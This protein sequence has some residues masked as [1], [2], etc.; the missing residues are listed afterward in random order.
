[1][2]RSA[3]SARWNS[4][5]WFVLVRISRSRFTDTI[6]KNARLASEIFFE[7]PVIKVFQH[8]AS[9]THR[10]MMKNHTLKAAWEAWK[11]FGHKLGDFQARLILTVFYFAVVGPFSLLIRFGSD[12]LTLKRDTARGW[13]VRKDAKGTPLERATQQF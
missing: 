2:L 8:D 9:Q 11:S 3:Q 13:S 1:M 7:Q 5:S 10:K 12:P 4:C 6:T